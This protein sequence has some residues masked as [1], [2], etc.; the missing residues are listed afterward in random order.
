MKALYSTVTPKRIIRLGYHEDLSTVASLIEKL[1]SDPTETGIAIHVF[2]L[3]K[4]DARRVA[5]TVQGLFRENLP[6][7]VLPITVSADERINAIV[8]SCG[9]TDAKRIGE[10]VQKLDT[11]QVAKVSEI[12]VFPLQFARAEALS[13]ILN[14]ALNTKPVPLNEQSPNAQSVLQF[15]T[16]TDLGQELVTAALKESVLI[17]PDPR[18]NSL[19]VSGPVD[20]MGLLEQIITR[21]DASSPQIAKIKV[22]S[23]QNADARQMAEMLTQMFRMTPTGGSVAGQRSVQYTLVRSVSADAGSPEEALASATVGT[24]EQ[25]ALS[26]TVDPRTNS[27]LVGGTDH[28]VTLVSQLIETLDSS[29]AHERNSEVIR[30]KNSQAADVAL[31]IRSFL[32]QERQKMVQALGVDAAA[33][34]QRMMDQEVAVVAEQISNTLL[35]SANHRYFEQVRRLIDELDQAQPQ[36]LIQVLLAEVTLD[37]AT[38][39]G[40]EW[41]HAGSKGDVAYGIGTDFGV[42]D[43]LKNFGGFSSAVTG[44]DFSFLLRALKQQGRLEVLSRPQIVTSDNKPATINIG[45]RVPLVDQSRL[46]AQNNLTTQF[47]YED[48]GVNLTVTPKISP[49]GFVKMEIGTTNSSISTSTVEVNKGSSVPIINQRKANTTVSAQ[50]G[51]TIIIGGLIASTDD[52]RV[53]KM[54]VLGEIP[55]LGALFRTSTTKRDRKELLIM[56]TPVVMENYQTKVKLSDPDEVL[57]RELDATNFKPLMKQGEMQ[58]N[59]LNPLYQTNRPSWREQSI[60]KTKAGSL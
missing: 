14:T 36:V 52:K 32:D 49:D 17:T 30:L 39:L 59:L 51:Q 5:T 35:L 37:N 54:P 21:L 47:R 12:K 57:R 20:Y 38:D 26:V 9:E 48:V 23:L 60:P 55:Y 11:D 3:A 18:M 42:A 29:T 1:D 19:I 33:A 8:V 43:S 15:I 31:A 58:R 28:Y 6:N 50:S 4:A 13:A 2:P 7:Q 22:F 10:L 34:A 27:L 53:K 16:R 25:T 45:Q 56:M 46:D 24:A 44:S 40:V 41:S